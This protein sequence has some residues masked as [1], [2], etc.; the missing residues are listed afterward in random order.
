MKDIRE[1]KMR[2][3]FHSSIIMRYIVNTMIYIIIGGYIVCVCWENT[4]AKSAEF[5]GEVLR[6]CLQENFY[7]SR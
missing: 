7:F 6:K 5:W 4:Y 3:L 1:T 2:Q